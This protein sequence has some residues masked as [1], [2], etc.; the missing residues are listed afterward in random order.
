MHI[1]LRDQ[2]ITRLHINVF[3]TPRQVDATSLTH[4]HRL[5]YEGL[6][7]LSIELRLEFF[8]LAGQHPCF[9]EEVV[10]LLENAVESHEVPG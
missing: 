3:K 10:L 1:P 8:L 9:R 7:L 6:S 4:I 2:L 5:Y